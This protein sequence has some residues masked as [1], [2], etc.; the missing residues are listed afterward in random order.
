MAHTENPQVII[1]RW[2]PMASVIEIC[3]SPSSKA[4]RDNPRL[5]HPALRITSNVKGLQAIHT[6][7]SVENQTFYFVNVWESHED[8]MAMLQDKE[9]S[10]EV[11]EGLA[12]YLPGPFEAHHVSCPP[13]ALKAI[14]A[15]VSSIAFLTL[16]E[17]KTADDVTP[18]L[19]QLAGGGSPPLPGLHASCFGN[20]IEEDDVYVF[21]TGWDS[22]EIHKKS[23]SESRALPEVVG[24][25]MEVAQVG[26]EHVP[27]S[28]YAE[29]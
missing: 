29:L 6:G 9:T 20:T 13:D 26:S 23:A 8:H 3:T 21:M 17:G 19:V 18:L 12:K 2:I 4:I 28:Q 1:L 16:K 27:L 7:I 25:L 5:I 14:R 15:P 22:V 11:A 24:K 10:G